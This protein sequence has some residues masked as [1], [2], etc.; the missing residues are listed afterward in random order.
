MLRRLLFS[1]SQVK[2]GESLS[3][4]ALQGGYGA[5]FA[6]QACPDRTAGER[7]EYKLSTRPEIGQDTEFYLGA[8]A[9]VRVERYEGHDIESSKFKNP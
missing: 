6:F 9:G 2:A 3:I 5:L 1:K 7:Q 8:A 4:T